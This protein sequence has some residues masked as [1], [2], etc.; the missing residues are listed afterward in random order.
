MFKNVMHHCDG[1]AKLSA[2]LLQSSWEGKTFSII[3]PVFTWS[4]ANHSNMMICCSR[5]VSN[6][7]VQMQKPLSAIWNFL[8]EWSF[9]S[10]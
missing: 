3:T 2:S 1:K 7:R 9:L 6:W 5:N 8:L 10:S 4:F